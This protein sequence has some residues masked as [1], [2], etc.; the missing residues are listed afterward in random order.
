MCRITKKQKT[1][2]RMVSEISVTLMMLV[3][4]WKFCLVELNWIHSHRDEKEVRKDE[5]RRKDRW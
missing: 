4:C 2:K 5:G 1:N 3:L